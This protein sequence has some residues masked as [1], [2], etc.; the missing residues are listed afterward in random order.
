MTLWSETNMFVQQTLSNTSRLASGLFLIK[1][2]NILPLGSEKRC[3]PFNTSGLFNTS[4]LVSS[5]LFI[6]Y[7]AACGGELLFIPVVR[8]NFAQSFSFLFAGF[9]CGVAK[10]NDQNHPS[11]RRNL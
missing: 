1:W 4:R 9:L 6:R 2:F 7:R 8:N 5:G 11:G 10:R 3:I